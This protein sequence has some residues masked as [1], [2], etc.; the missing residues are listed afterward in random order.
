MVSSS[1]S[2]FTSASPHDLTAFTSIFSHCDDG[3]G[4]IPSVSDV[5]VVDDDDDDDDDDE[6]VVVVVVIVGLVIAST[7]F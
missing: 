4:N 6:V 7:A 2:N 3:V 1:S 5:I